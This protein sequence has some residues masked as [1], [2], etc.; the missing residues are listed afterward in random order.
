MN[1][2]VRRKTATPP[3]PVSVPPPD[4]GLRRIDGAL[5]AFA[6]NQAAEAGARGDV[7]AQRRWRVLMLRLLGRE[8]GRT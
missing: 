2:A 5:R 8:P 6:A 4:H 7:R 3:R 1:A